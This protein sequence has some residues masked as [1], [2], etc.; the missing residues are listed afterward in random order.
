M[1]T[2]RTFVE[3]SLAT[4]PFPTD[5]SRAF[6]VSVSND[7]TNFGTPIATGAGTATPTTI[8][9][10]PQTARF[11]RVTLTAAAANLWSIAD[12]DVITTTLP[13][14]GW[15]ATATSTS[16][17]NAAAN[18]LDG[19]ATTKWTSAGAQTGQSF[20]VD[21]AARQTF[22][23]LTLDSGSSPNNF[24]R[25]YSVFVSN[26]STNFGTAVVT[27]TAT[28]SPV[29]INLPAQFAQYIKITAGTN[30]ASWTIAELTVTGQPTVQT[31]L[32][33]SGWTATA[34]S[35]SSTTT[36]AG[37]LDG[38]AATRWTSAG[39]QTGQSFTVD[40]LALRTFNQITADAGTTSTQF[41]RHYSLFVSNDGV[42][43]G[44][45]VGSGT[46][47][48]ALAVIN[49]PTQTARYVKIVQDATNTNPWSIQELNVFGPSVAQSGWN[50]TASST[51]GTDLALNAIDGSM[52]TRWTSAAAQTNGQTF[53][54]DLGAA[55]TFNQVTLDAGTSTGNY[56]RGYSVSV[57]AD[58]TTFGA[59]VATG[60]GSSQLVTINFATTTARAIRITQTGTAANAWSIHELN[61]ARIAQPCDTV[62]CTAS[63]TCHTSTCDPNTGLCSN[64]VRPDGQACNDG[65][66]C[67]LGETCQA[68]VCKQAPTIT[69]VAGDSVTFYQSFE[70]GTTVE[71]AG[72]PKIPYDGPTTIVEAPGLFGKGADGSTSANI[73]YGDA[74]GTSINLAKPGSLSYWFKNEKRWR[75][76][77]GVRRHRRFCS[78]QDGHKRGACVSRRLFRIRRCG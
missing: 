9:F 46:V 6:Q 45:A 30:A 55:Q 63:D 61:V 25:S 20:Q 27:G 1:V 39:A 78:H 35:T 29:I 36:T 74:T 64:Q 12:F 73:S 72:G 43:F 2:P 56:P 70:N 68:G 67:T 22:S 18:A 47:S 69:C 60:V 58:G 10:A 52:G 23:Q 42:N 54:V 8:S 57:S 13:R 66:V 4:T 5:Y 44:S 38:N 48:G 65:N 11:V 14:T 50:A 62:T 17:S 3:L 15:F 32:P 7:G 21:M 53:Q 28:A 71:I 34:T 16:G 76:A 37:A 24:P 51:G 49:P 77:V 75:G 33:R 40:M 59:P 19:V 26:D 41:P 31:T